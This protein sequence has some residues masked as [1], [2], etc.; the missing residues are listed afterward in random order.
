MQCKRHT[1]T[2]SCEHHEWHILVDLKMCTFVHFNTHVWFVDDSSTCTHRLMHMQTWVHT[3]THT[4]M[5]VRTHTQTHT[6][7][8]R[9]THTHMLRCVLPAHSRTQTPPYAHTPQHIP[10]PPHTHTCTHPHKTSPPKKFK[11]KFQAPNSQTAQGRTWAKEQTIKPHLH[12]HMHTLVH[13]HTHARTQI[14]DLCLMWLCSGWRTFCGWTHWSS[15]PDWRI[16]RP[17]L[18]PW[19]FAPSSSSVAWP[20][21]ILT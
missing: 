15:K 10:S 9:H 16:S 6:Q 13:T 2:H 12:A 1:C 7:T 17:T 8:D 19:L 4:C 3:C 21:T 18:F 20:M 11:K 14:D 5:H